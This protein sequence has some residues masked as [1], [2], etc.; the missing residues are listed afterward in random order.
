MTKKNVK[1]IIISGSIE[2]NGIVNFDSNDQK[3]AII[4][5][6]LKDGMGISGKINDNVKFGKKSFY[7]ED[8]KFDENG[9]SLGSKYYYKNIIS[10]DCLRHAVY[11]NDVDMVN[12]SIIYNPMIL[13]MY[14]TSFVGLTR[15]YMFALKKNGISMKRT[16]CLTLTDA[17]QSNNAKSVI[18]VGTTMGDRDDKSMI[19]KETVGDITYDFKGNIDIKNLQFISSDLFYDRLALNSDW[20]SNGLISKHMVKHYGKNP[21]EL[22]KEGC[23]THL[24]SYLSKTICEYGILLNNDFTVY[25]IKELL[26]RIIRI[27]ITRSTAYAKINTLKIKLV[28]D[29]I[30][31]DSEWITLDSDEAIDNLD[32]SVYNYYVE[33]TDKDRIERDK[34]LEEYKKYKDD[35]N[36]EKEEKKKNSKKGKKDS[37]DSTTETTESNSTE[38]K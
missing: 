1:S 9:K 6:K 15:G 38:N 21:E 12:S 16:S 28:D 20:I 23:F 30:N 34:M 19:F 7:K 33:S 26:K 27:N 5:M 35:K 10:G 14:E 3:F 13:S 18:S 17:E 37:S 29:I 8:E 2:G 11:Q 22:Y 4:D 24:S 32:F 25:L 31:D 36:K